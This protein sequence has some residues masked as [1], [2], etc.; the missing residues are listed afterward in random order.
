MDS[1]TL[2][3]DLNADDEAHW[4]LIT[5]LLP[6]RNSALQLKLLGELH[7]FRAL[8]DGRQ[9]MADP[10]LDQQLHCLRQ[11]YRR[12]DWQS[13]YNNISRTLTAADARVIPITSED[14][15]PQLQQIAKPPPLL[16]LRGSLE[17]LHLPQL[18]IVGSR[19]MTKGG[20]NH[21][22][23]WATYLAANGF[24]VTSG[25]ALGIDGAA[26]RGALESPNGKTIAVMATGI[27]K[28]YPARHV[29]LAEQIV[30]RGGALITEFPPGTQPR[31]A[32]FPQRNRIISGLSLGVLVVEAAVKSGSLITAKYALEQNREVFAIPGS[33]NNPQSKGCHQLIKQGA[34][35]VESVDEI[36]HELHGPLGALREQVTSPELSELLPELSD[37]EEQLLALMGYDP[38]LIDD[39]CSPWPM[40]KLSKL[41]VSLEL[42]GVISNQQGYFCRI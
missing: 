28:R 7:S 16:Y 8:L 10:I 25:L 18:A 42:K 26:H 38:I 31:P 33:I 22:R 37:E 32:H 4:G 5:Q 9:T 1:H 23:S 36:V 20:E 2:K 21:A 39:I 11:H 24:T 27:D 35:L 13:Q 6:E 14:Y 40:D 17:S 41:L 30:Q 34:T 29:Q 3:P 12:G 19:R 15:P